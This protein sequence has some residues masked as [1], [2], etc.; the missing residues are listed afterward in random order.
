MFSFQGKAFWAD[1][2]QGVLH[3]DLHDKDS[4]F[5]LNFIKFPK[6]YRLPFSEPSP[7]E[8][9]EPHKSRTMGCA[10]DSVKFICIDH[11][12]PGNE[13]VKV[14]NLDRSPAVERK[15]GYTLEGALREGRLHTGRVGGRHCAPVPYLDGGWYTLPAA[16]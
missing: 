7:D 2:L 12:H 4:G 15:Q 14:W 5:K 3:C 1:L 11:S 16:G 10:G 13:T 9:D 6:A 8:L